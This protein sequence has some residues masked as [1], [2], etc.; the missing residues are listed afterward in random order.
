MKSRC[1]KRSLRK[2][3]FLLALRL[4]GRFARNVPS[5]EE[6]G[7]TD[8]FAGYFNVF[9]PIL[10]RSIRQMLV[11]NF[12][13]W[14]LND[15]VEV[16]E[17]IK[18]VVVLSSLPPQTYNYAFSRRSRAVTAKNCTKKRDARTDLLFCQ[19]KPISFLPFSLTSPWS[20]LTLATDVSI[21]YAEVIIDMDWTP[22][23]TIRLRQKSSQPKSRLDWQT[24]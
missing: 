21:T 5:G 10:S 12:W 9:A 14:I 4:W 2:Y 15:S 11:P 17:K 8:V 22:L 24:T 19:S 13:S 1:F 18:K 6:R 7:E 16:Q 20:L 23:S 3:P